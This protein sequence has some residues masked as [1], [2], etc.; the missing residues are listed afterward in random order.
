MSKLQRSF[1]K[2]A[3]HPVWG[4]RDS[5]TSL[6]DGLSFFKEPMFSASRS[7][8]ALVIYEPNR[9]SFSQI[10]PLFF[11]RTEFASIYDVD[12]HFVERER[13]IDRYYR[14]GSEFT[15]VFVQTWL[16]HDARNLLHL[17]HR[18]ADRMP[19][20]IKVY[21]DSFANN[22]LRLGQ[23]LQDYDFYFKK[24]IFVDLKKYAQPTIGDTN[25][26][27]YYNSY[28]GLSNPIVEWSV[29]TSLIP[30]LRLSPNFLTDPALMRWLQSKATPLDRECR[31]IDIHARL[32]GTD[33][34]GWYS[35]MRRDAE[36]RVLDIDSINTVTGIG[37]KQRVFQEELSRSKI[38]FSPFGYGEICWRDIEAIASGAV[39]LKPDMSHL[40]TEPDLYRDGE[41]YVAINWDFS[42]LSSKVKSLLSDEPRR[43]SIAERAR[44]VAQSYLRQNG[45][46]AT[47]ADV[48]SHKADVTVS[49]SD[50]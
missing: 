34:S 50:P 3:Q 6:K 40:R 19:S 18:I 24:S 37:V 9:I 5:L 43:R 46:V 30:K 32:G 21:V 2:F 42:D 16:T 44:H 29:P 23:Y 15:H 33:G 49:S 4:A 1:A 10:Y 39:L 25:L 28:Y 27:D 11:Y 17:N 35:E 38:C 12:F 13:F 36:Q 45:P 48:F 22:D 7:K 8:R 47:Y 26:S 41:T 20:A 31:D 14:F